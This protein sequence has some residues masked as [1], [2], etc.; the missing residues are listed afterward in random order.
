MLTYGNSRICI[1]L[2]AQ[3]DVYEEAGTRK[4]WCSVCCQCCSCCLCLE[5]KC[6]S[7]YTQLD[8]TSFGVFINGMSFVYAWAISDTL[9]VLVFGVYLNCA[10]A[11][12]CSYQSNAL[13]AAILAPS[14]A[15]LSSKLK[16]KSLPETDIVAVKSTMQ[17]QSK[18]FQTAI[19]LMVG[20]QITNTV[21]V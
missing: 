5:T 20:W 6:P 3:Y 4:G 14:C 7:C 2:T 8:E 12:S 1:Q 13:Y 17:A 9:N 18:L 15:W 21:E 11:T 10:S 19:A 16:S